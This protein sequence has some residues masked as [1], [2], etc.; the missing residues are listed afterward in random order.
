M[1]GLIV[2]GLLGLSMGQPGLWATHAAADWS[3]SSLWGS[4][5]A[6]ETSALA[7]TIATESAS[8]EQSPEFQAWLIERRSTLAATYHTV[9]TTPQVVAPPPLKL[10]Q[11][12]LL[13]RNFAAEGYPVPQNDPVAAAAYNALNRVI[14]SPAYQEYSADMVA[15]MD[16]PHASQAFEFRA[17]LVNFNVCPPDQDGVQCGLMYGAAGV[18]TGGGIWAATACAAL[19]TTCAGVAAFAI[20]GGLFIF[21]YQLYSAN[22][23]HYGAQSCNDSASV[24]GYVDPYGTHYAVDYN[25]I[26]CSSQVDTMDVYM[27]LDCPGCNGG[28]GLQS[29]QNYQ[30]N[31]SSSFQPDLLYANAPTGDYTAANQAQAYRGYP[32]PTGGGFST[33][34]GEA[35][36]SG[37][38]G[39]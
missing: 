15:L 37:Y 13:I 14:A 31:G 8:A 2:L 22:N 1:S 28:Y 5:Q 7:T 30:G 4:Y 11:G 27:V 35:E 23:Y 24:G 32:T 39:G 10:A 17:N 21:A 19:A 25:D 38:Y 29:E 6:L 34:K 16:D 18:A 12:A 26:E 3:A 20:L 33:W 36:G 9:P